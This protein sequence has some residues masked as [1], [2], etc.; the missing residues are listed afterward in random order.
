MLYLT[1]T[2]RNYEIERKHLS[3]VEKFLIDLA[4]QNFL[5]EQ[6]R[7]NNLH[8]LIRPKNKEKKLNIIGLF[9]S[10]PRSGKVTQ[11]KGESTSCY[12]RLHAIAVSKL[13]LD[14]IEADFYKY[15]FMFS[16]FYR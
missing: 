6:L 5:K 13:K 3:N 11:L 16:R 14:L 9:V 1:T 10:K 2:D 12:A 15:R 8:A 4:N 7:V